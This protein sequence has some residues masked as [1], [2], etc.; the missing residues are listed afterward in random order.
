MHNKLHFLLLIMSFLATCAN[1]QQVTISGEGSRVAQSFYTDIN[2]GFKT[3]YPD[4]NLEYSTAY[5]LSDLISGGVN[6]LV[7]LQPITAAEI[8][9]FPQ[10]PLIFPAAVA[11]V[12]LAYNLP[13]SPAVT[14]TADQIA[15]IYLGEITN[16]TAIDPMLPNITI[17]PFGR[18]DITGVTANFTQ[19]LTSAVATWPASLVG[20]QVPFTAPVQ[21]VDGGGTLVSTL[22]TTVGS[23]GYASLDDAI[24]G[25]GLALASII[26]QAG[27]AIAPTVESIG[28]S[29]NGL[30][31]TPSL[32]MTAINSSDPAAYPIS[33]FIT[34]IVNSNQPDLA[35]S[36]AVRN[37]LS[38]IAT[39]GQQVT[40]PNNFAP[41][42]IAI[43][44]QYLA[45][46]Q[47]L[48]IAG[49]SS[50][51]QAILNKYC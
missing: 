30:V 28:A 10:A 49:I 18:S 25:T 6:Y 1:A 24:G 35:T 9:Q 26:N 16:W 8:A 46:L 33:E 32:L 3:L 21:L 41:L 13:G 45:N 40:T 43:V 12:A 27:F 7:N 42:S 50:L 5:N 14:L 2:D 15:G 4:V 37:Y 51:S 47:L 11:G 22:E 48:S 38:Y 29:Q 17:V 23:I 36:I 31:I 20:V 34:T 19:Y 39:T 44:T